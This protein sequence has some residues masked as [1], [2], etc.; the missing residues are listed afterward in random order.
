MATLF[1]SRSGYGPISRAFHWLMALLFLWQFTSAVLRVFAKDTSIYSFFWS[2]HHQMG[3][4]LL[5][6][7]L[8]RG[9]WGLLNVNRRPH[10]PNLAGKV[11]VLGHL[12]IYALMFAVPAVALLRTYGGGKGFSFLGIEIFE[13][14]GVRNAALMAPGNA[15]HGLL[16]WALLALI[17]GHILL[18]LVHHFLIE[19]DTLRFMLGGKKSAV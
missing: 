5:A 11:V 13:Q 9:L 2:A 10:R 15:L 19:D 1:D 17:A 6:L 7:V 12:T 4:A 3:F 16:G 14:T 8:L 18:A